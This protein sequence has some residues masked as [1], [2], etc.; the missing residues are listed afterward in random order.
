MNGVE[1]RFGRFRLDFQAQRLLREDRPVRLPGRAFDILCA[2]AA[3]GGEVVTKD[4]LM[5][6]LWP[7]RSVEENN[8]HVHLSML[9]KALQQDNSDSHIVTVPSRGYRL[10]GLQTWPLPGTRERPL[11]PLPDK[12][13]IAV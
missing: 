8:L 7:G 12:P 4:E 9:R 10:V 2:L 6:R 5:R 11:L 13:S 3:A 1:V